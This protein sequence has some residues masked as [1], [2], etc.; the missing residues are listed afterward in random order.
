[1]MAR[2][3]TINEEELQPGIAPSLFFHGGSTPA[4]VNW[5]DWSLSRNSQRDAWVTDS[6]TAKLCC[7]SGF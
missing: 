6:A 3:V 4:A 2:L 5:D 1:M 7:R